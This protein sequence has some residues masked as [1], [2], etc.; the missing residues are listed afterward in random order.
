[1]IIRFNWNYQDGA[2]FTYRE[3]SSTESGKG[4]LFL[5]PS[6]NVELILGCHEIFQ[7]VIREFCS[8]EM[9]NSYELRLDVDLPFS[10]DIEG[11]LTFHDIELAQYVY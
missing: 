6:N 3:P 5:N 10:D 7:P 11:Q 8:D 1:M 9:W 2:L 4:R